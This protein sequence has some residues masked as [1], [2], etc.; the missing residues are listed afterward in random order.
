[1][2]L[3]ALK[4]WTFLRERGGDAPGAIVALGFVAASTAIGV[5]F[6]LE[7][8]R[9][10]P[11][12]LGAALVVLALMAEIYKSYYFNLTWKRQRFIAGLAGAPLLLLCVAYSLNASHKFSE[13]NL[14]KH[15]RSERTAS[16]DY[17]AL[18]VEEMYK[19]EQLKPI[20]KTRLTGA[21]E[22]E[23]NGLLI[24]PGVNECKTIDGPESKRF[25]PR[26]A[27]LRAE[28]ANAKDRDKLTAELDGIKQKLGAISR[29]TQDNAGPVAALL[30]YAGAPRMNWS[31]MTARLIMLIIEAGSLIA[32]AVLIRGREAPAPEREPRRA[33]PAVAPSP[34][35]L[36]EH[37]P[38][39]I[40]AFGDKR[41][42]DV[43][44]FLDEKV[45]RV[46]GGLYP[47]RKLYAAYKAWHGDKAD[48]A[49]EIRRHY[50][51]SS[52]SSE[53]SARASMAT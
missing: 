19:R 28:L 47:S 34:A 53:I 23:L 9:D 50:E 13:E 49:Q 24:Q 12:G 1:M 17:K 35:L 33:P 29:E 4:L 25:C 20:E 31:E 46:R 40:V 39:E 11:A 15:A 14:I 45:E 52:T 42:A 8:G 3:F 18:E 41:V 10:V 36:I 37:Q 38:E 43:A 22:A 27:T 30:L 2:K 21:I 44:R 51:R 32:P 16:S 6:A 26:I 5:M 7:L 48:L